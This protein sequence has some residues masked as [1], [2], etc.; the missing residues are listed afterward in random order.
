MPLIFYVTHMGDMY[1][2]EVPLGNSVM[3]GAV[4][5]MIDG[6]LG[7]CGGAMRCG[8]CHCYVDAKWV[9]KVGEASKNEQAL[10]NTSGKQQANSRLSCQITVREDLDNLVVHLPDAQY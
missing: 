6:I 8:T 1:E 3:Q 9:D 5:N 7:E 10:I 2:A 4:D